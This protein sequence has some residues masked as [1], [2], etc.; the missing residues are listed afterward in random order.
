M[1]QSN[2][3]NA[4][5]NICN[6]VARYVHDFSQFDAPRFHPILMTVPQ[7]FGVCTAA[8]LSPKWLTAFPVQGSG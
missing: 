4:A 6:D 2:E 7:H 1:D 5:R 8:P 3:A